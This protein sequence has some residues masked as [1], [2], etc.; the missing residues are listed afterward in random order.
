MNFIAENATVTGQVNLGKGTSIWFGAVIRGDWA[1][2]NIG[3]HSNVQDNCVIHVSKD[4]G[5][6]I[7]DYVSIG[8]GAVVHSCDIGNNVLI[9]I[10]ATV[11]HDCKIGD[12]CLIA[13][14]AL[15][16]PGKEVPSNSLFMGVPGRVM[17]KVTAEELEKIKENAREYE[18]HASRQKTFKHSQPTTCHD[19]KNNP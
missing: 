13:A 15:V 16:P 7:G 14:G 1:P 11:L 9:G 19:R 8:H 18:E 17:R 10:N 5:V 3:A 4:K 12:N 2:I 6:D